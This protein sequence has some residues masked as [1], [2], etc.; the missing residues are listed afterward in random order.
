MCRRFVATDDGFGTY[1]HT[2]KSRTTSR[3][4]FVNLPFARTLC[5]GSTAQ[6]HCSDNCSTKR[7]Q[8]ELKGKFS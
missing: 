1:V 5:S 4:L 6:P 8:K 2:Y 7:S 3:F